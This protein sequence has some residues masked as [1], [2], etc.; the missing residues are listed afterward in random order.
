MPPPS[1]RRFVAPLA[2]SLLLL[3]IGGGAAWWTR[4]PRP[5]IAIDPARAAT[6]R[7]ELVPLA[8]AAASRG[9][10][11]EWPD[12]PL[13]TRDLVALDRTAEA[14]AP[15]HALALQEAS[16]HGVDLRVIDAARA[17]V[18]DAL[19]VVLGTPPDALE[20]AALLSDPEALAKA[21]ALRFRSDAEGRTRLPF[22]RDA[23]L[24][25]AFAGDALGTLMIEPT[26][27]FPVELQLRPRFAVEVEVVDG[28]GAPLAGI[29]VG[30][31]REKQ[32]PLDVTRVETS[33]A[34]GRCRFTDL[35]LTLLPP[36]TPWA[37]SDGPAPELVRERW[38]V[39]VRGVAGA[40]AQQTLELPPETAE[41]VRLV[42]AERGALEV[43]VALPEG[44]PWPEG[45]RVYL[46]ARNE[47]GERRDGQLE[48]DPQ[49]RAT[50]APLELGFG[51]TVELRASGLAATRTPFTALREADERRELRLEP[52]ATGCWLVGEAIAPDGASL[53]DRNF[54]ASF[55][56]S[57][58]A[59]EIAADH[60][61]RIDLSQH[62]DEG[63]LEGEL[64]LRLEATD[65]LQ[66]PLA[67]RL[68]LHHAAEGVID[69]GA[70]TLV[71]RPLVAAGRVVDSD[72]LPVEGAWVNAQSREPQVDRS[73]NRATALQISDEQGRFALFGEFPPGPASL[74]AERR[75]LIRSAALPIELGAS[76]LLVTLAAGGSCEASL[77]ADGPLSPTWF[78]AALLPAG[79]ADTS[80]E[81]VAKGD[82][83]LRFP[84]LPATP[85]HFVL[86]YAS[87]SRRGELLRI[88]D[89][90]IAPFTLTQDA[91][92]QEL[93]PALFVPTTTFHVLEPDGAPATRGRVAIDPG[94]RRPR[95]M[96]DLVDGI[97]T[98][99]CFGE[100][101]DWLIAVPGW[102]HASGKQR[103]GRLD[104][105]LE[106]LLIATVVVKGLPERDDG[107]VAVEIEARPQSN[108]LRRLDL[109]AR[110]PLVDGVAALSL[111]AW[112]K[113][114]LSVKLQRPL[115]DGRWQDAPR[116]TRPPRLDAID[117][118]RDQPLRFE[119]KAK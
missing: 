92:L 42:V 15:L 103:P 112:G 68:P 90:A 71:A 24:V 79:S 99:P 55:E 17:P 105:V 58:L 31:G 66:A 115:P 48:L 41:P 70:L 109:S 98:T 106:P 18:A 59:A 26:L 4:A 33:D 29:P 119:R 28:E 60:R 23:R 101:V 83:R 20:R 52:L 35:D 36:R 88:A 64:L 57:H 5:T 73:G 65:R 93:D 56:G 61:F 45:A 40:A 84:L 67:A 53:A 54:L 14:T 114:D 47:A 8:E 21:A 86:S 76:D 104:V 75:G 43:V 111:P 19:V 49:G 117:L 100:T 13:A 12:A 32:S 113:W 50:F 77:R 87:D 91:R 38:R 44:M 63:R 39:A 72:G 118:K 108:A 62:G 46:S 69:L 102:Q 95:G 96:V 81:L 110:A 10:G 80:A 97:A 89:V 82:G 6:G 1:P 34:A 78:R 9:G 7:H 16:A 22:A 2:L 30:W 116:G 37:S 94:Q 3:A 74:T 25:V 107:L 85:H 11:A 51:G 27:F